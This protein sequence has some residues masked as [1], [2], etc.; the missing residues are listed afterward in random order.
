MQPYDHRLT[1]LAALEDQ[2]VREFRA[3][4][5]LILITR[6][7]RTALASGDIPNLI[8]LVD[9]KDHL[10]DDLM[11]L[12]DT[13][14]ETV[15]AWGIASSIG[16]EDLTIADIVSKL[17]PAASARFSRLREGIL[18]QVTELRDLNRGNQALAASAL[19]RVDA[20][21]SFFVSLD[22]G[23]QTYDVPGTS[24]VSTP[25]PTYGLEQWA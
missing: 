12:E 7:E 20:V 6:E 14:I 18:A 10:L 1:L 13:R 16:K 21:R 25:Q 3:Y 2:L 17:E 11:A 22:D 23:P 24:I 4:Q 15:S 5:S 19:D 8:A 9:Q